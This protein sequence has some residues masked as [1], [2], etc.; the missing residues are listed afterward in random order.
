[1]SFDQPGYPEAQS[2][3]VVVANKIFWTLG[4]W[5]VE[6]FIAKL[7]P[8][9]LTIADDVRISSSRLASRARWPDR[10]SMTSCGDPIVHPMARIARSLHDSCRGG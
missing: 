2:A 3:A 10:I 9:D 7:R 5:Q 4:Y 6:N 8:D 1:M